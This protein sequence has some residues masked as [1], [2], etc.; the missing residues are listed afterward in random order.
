MEAAVGMNV[1]QDSYFWMT[2]ACLIFLIVGYKFGRA[3]LLKLLDARTDKI[4][5]DLEEAEQLKE[6]AQELLASYQKKHRDAIQTAQKIMENARETASRLQREAESKLEESLERRE[7]QLL[8]RIARAQAQAVEDVRLQ[9]A[10]I[11]TAAAAKV[12]RE[13]LAD[14]DSKLVD[15]AIND[16]SSRLN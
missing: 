5:A 3:P 16:L 7:T 10:N 4:R 12:L 13:A 15:T 11:A 9:A 14:Q 1:L 8:E 2:L 6:Q